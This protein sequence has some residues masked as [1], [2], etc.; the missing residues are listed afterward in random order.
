MNQGNHWPLGSRFMSPEEV[1][2]QLAKATR[3]VGGFSMTLGD[4]SAST[5]ADALPGEPLKNKQTSPSREIRPVDW[6]GRP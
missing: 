1:S 6:F 2:A 5:G 3:S 4:A